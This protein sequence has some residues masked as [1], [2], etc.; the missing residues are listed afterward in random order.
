MKTCEC[1]LR[2]RKW[3]LVTQ[4]CET[5]GGYTVTLP[6]LVRPE[7]LP[8]SVTAA[9]LDYTGQSERIT[10]THAYELIEAIEP[11]IIEGF[12]A[13]EVRTLKALVNHHKALIETVNELISVRKLTLKD[14]SV[15]NIEEKSSLS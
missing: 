7:N 13:G 14:D 2:D 12:D 6:D 3:N 10:R 9:R 11:F 4:K 8:L 1:E 5:C 15:L